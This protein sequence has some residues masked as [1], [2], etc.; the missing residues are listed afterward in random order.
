MLLSK[1]YEVFHIL[2]V[3]SLIYPAGKAHVPHYIVICVLSG[4]T[5]FFHIISLMKRF[6][7]TQL[8]NTECGFW[9]SQQVLSE[10]LP[11]LW[12]IQQRH[13]DQ[14]T[15]FFMQSNHH[16]C[17]IIIKLELLN[18]FWKNAQ[19]T[20]FMNIRPVGGEMVRAGRWM[21]RYTSSLTRL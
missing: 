14:W 17:Q 5:T 18:R 13:Y 10:T 11:V 19:I 21:K 9:F 3:C 15:D 2:S 6:S 8:L 12:S 20:S 16:S 7:R 4:S 1:S